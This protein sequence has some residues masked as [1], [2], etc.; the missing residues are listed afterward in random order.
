LLP[1]AKFAYNN[2]IQGSIHQTPFF[3]NHV[4][5][6]QLDQ[7]NFNNVENPTA[8]D[9]VTWLFKIHTKMKDR[10][11]GA[12]DRQ[13]DNADKSQK[14]HLVIN[15]EDKV[16]LLCHNLKTTHLYTTLDFHL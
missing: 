6:P 9:L 5:H 3:T 14:A 16:W 15:I 11:F 13:K 10:F 2:T 4:C 12:Q 1:L 8:E 7:F